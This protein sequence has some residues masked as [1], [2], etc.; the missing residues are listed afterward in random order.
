MDFIQQNIIP[1]EVIVQL[2][3]FLIVFFVLKAHAWG[4]ILSSL[5]ARREKIKKDFDAIEKA[6]HEIEDLK[7]KYTAH[8]QKIEDEARAKLQ[9]AIDEG[10][11]IAREIQDKARED[12]QA[13]FEKAKE[14]LVLETAKART[15]LRREIAELTI[16]VSEKI[17][18]EKMTDSKQQ[19]KILDLIQELEKSL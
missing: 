12:S 18:G 17:I 4:P 9:E 8:L 16:Q 5:E 10:R 6:R 2:C 15:T 11:R 1:G 19:E 13:S 7:T 14:N 3:A